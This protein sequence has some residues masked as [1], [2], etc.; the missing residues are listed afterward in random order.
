MPYVLH[1][2][3]SRTGHFARRDAHE[4]WRR[5]YLERLARQHA[6]HTGL[7]L[8]V[9]CRIV[10]ALSIGAKKPEPEAPDYARFEDVLT[11]ERTPTLN[12]AR[13]VTAEEDALIRVLAAEGLH[14]AA[15]AKSTAG[16]RQSSDACDLLAL[17]SRALSAS[18]GDI[19]LLGGVGQRPVTW[20]RLR[21]RCCSEGL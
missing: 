13:K 18:Q 3:L 10:A 11:R 14:A 12:T 7:S 19:E 9:A 21:N 4:R 1:N 5:D 20:V 8:P 17:R 2:S 6:D 15:I 16:T